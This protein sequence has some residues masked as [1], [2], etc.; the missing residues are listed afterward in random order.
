M[1]THKRGRPI[2]QEVEYFGDENDTHNS[3]EKFNTLRGITSKNKFGTEHIKSDVIDIVYHNLKSESCLEEVK[4]DPHCEKCGRGL[5]SL[6]DFFSTDTLQ[7]CNCHAMR[8]VDMTQDFKPLNFGSD[9]GIF[10]HETHEEIVIGKEE[11]G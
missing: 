10:L 8:G 4:E 7:S 2:K 1:T 5:L 6:T 9:S 3:E 11:E